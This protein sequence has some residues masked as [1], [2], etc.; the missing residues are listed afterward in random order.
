[1]VT[2]KEGDLFTS[3]CQTLVNAVNCI[4]IMGGGIALAFKAQFPYKY[5]NDYVQDCFTGRL[6][7]GKPTLWKPAEGKWV[8]NFP[9]KDNLSPS[10]LSYVDSGLQY[11]TVAEAT[12]RP[13]FCIREPWLIEHGVTSIAFPALGAGL[14][15]LDWADVQPIMHAYLSTLPIPVEIYLPQKA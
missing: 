15:G 3:E 14:G 11:L 12:E 10:R 1:M 2:Y 4:G 6:T 7:V 9:T 5:F 13:D 8:L